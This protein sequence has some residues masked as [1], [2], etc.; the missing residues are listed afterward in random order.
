MCGSKFPI[1]G[2]NGRVKNLPK[3][4]YISLITLSK[5]Y[6]LTHYRFINLYY[7][8]VPHGLLQLAR[9]PQRDTCSDRVVRVGDQVNK[10]HD[11]KCAPPFPR[12]CMVDSAAF[13]VTRSNSI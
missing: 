12:P 11:C 5:I 9:Y 1:D 10:L 3:N 7:L 13:E 2:A 6:C 4:L 8:W